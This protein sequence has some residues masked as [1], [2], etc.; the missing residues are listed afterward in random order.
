[1]GRNDRDRHLSAAEYFLQV[2]RE[3]IIAEFRRKIYY[4]PKNK[5]YW[6]RV[7]AYKRA[8]IEEI[9]RRNHLISI[10]TSDA[11]MDEIRSQLFDHNGKPTFQLTPEDIEN[12]Y[13]TGNEFSYKGEIWILD[14]VMED[15]KLTLYNP[16]IERFINVLP[17]ETHRIL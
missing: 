10:F 8:K 5:R 11:K 12:Y 4:S 1:M 15:G 13:S 9:S 14:Q 7:M 16:I 2:Q 3:Y 17:S 6:E